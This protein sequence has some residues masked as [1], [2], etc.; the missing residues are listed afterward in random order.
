[1]SGKLDLFKARM[2]DQAGS[3][4]VASSLE[5]AI[6]I[7]VGILVEQEVSTAVIARM[8][9][10]MGDKVAQS[11]K[12]A[13]IRLIE[14]KGGDVPRLISG[15]DAGITAASFAVAE[16]GSIVEV[17]YDDADRL[18]SALPKVHVCLLPRDR[19]VEGMEDSAP[20]LREATRGSGCST[21]SFISGPSRTGDIELKLVL[22]VHGPHQLHAL[23][24]G[25]K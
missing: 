8:P 20:L 5:D 24:F 7:L 25:E 10:N 4:H 16:T 3:V 18:A 22:G 1:M 12:S 6:R 2:E 21:I 14:P 17:T 13:G 11:V 23:V 15:A 9:P 19:I